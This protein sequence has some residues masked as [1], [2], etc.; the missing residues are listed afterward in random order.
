MRVT[1]RLDAGTMQDL[2]ELC[3]EFNVTISVIVRMLLKRGI[4]EVKGVD[5]AQ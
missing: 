5:T 4:D 3:E 1:I 2:T